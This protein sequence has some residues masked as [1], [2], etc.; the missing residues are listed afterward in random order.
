MGNLF[1]LLVLVAVSPHNNKPSEKDQ[2]CIHAVNSHVNDEAAKVSW[3]VL[4]SEDLRGDEVSN[5]PANEEHGH[6]GALLCLPRRVS[7]NHGN[8]HVSLGEEELC[9]VEG[10][11][12]PT[13][14]R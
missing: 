6:G 14:I 5:R 7:C 2:E 13:R 12:H 4:L 11:E 10:N 3:S 9:A 1:T 8:D